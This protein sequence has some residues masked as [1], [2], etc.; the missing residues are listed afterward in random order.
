MSSATR[1][2]I[3]PDYGRRIKE[4]REI[5]GLTQTQLAKL[6]GV[7]YAS[8]NRWENSQSRP[9]NLAW[10]RI[11]DLELSLQESSIQE[12]N[13]IS[14]GSASHSLDFSAPPEV[15]STIAEAHRLAYGHLFNPT[16]ASETSLIDPLPHQR[17]AV[18][19][20]MLRQSPLRFLL[21]DDAGA[22]K[23]IMT[24]LY[25]REMLARRLI[26]RVLIV[27]PAGLV[28]N[29]ERE[30]RTLFRLRFR[31][32][33][34]LDA[35]AAN[36][37]AAPESDLVIVSVDTLAG[38]RMFAHLGDTATEPYDLVVFDEAHKLS[39][40]RQPDF[41]VRKTERYR[42]AEAIAGAG[43][44]GSR[45]AI[46]WSAQH[47]LLLTAT[48]HMGKDLPYYY[49]WRLLL[50][51]TLPT[52]EAFGH[53]QF[54]AKLR[55]RHFIRRTKEELVRFDG[56]PLF[57][58]RE[59]N[60]FS[61]ALTQGPGSEQE[62][63]DATTD[64]IRIYYNKARVLNRSAARL[65]MSVF[66]RRL[67]SS[68]YALMRS[69][70]RRVERLEDMIERIRDGRLTE[71]QLI[72]QQQRLHSPDDA[73]EITTADE[74]AEGE[75]EP[76]RLEEF[77]EQVLGGVIA[78][79]LAELEVERLK[80][81]DLLDRA[82]SL[83]DSGEESKFEK[84]REVLEDPKYAGEKFIIFTEH[85]DTADFLVRRLEGL[86]FTGQIATMH[87]GM[88]YQER[89]RQVEFF[90]RPGTN[91]GANFLVATDAAGEGIN[92]Q[93]CWLM[94]N[95]DIPWN[96]ARLE[97]RMG[98]I[99]RYGQGHDPVVVA[100][101]VA[102]ATREGRVL[103]TL[104]EK[105][106]AIRLQLQ[107]D[108]VFDVIGRLFEGVSI[109]DYIEQTLTEGESGEAISRLEGAL[110]E[111][112]VRAIQE[113]E[114]RLFGQVGDVARELD[115][116]NG[117]ADH[118]VYRRLLPG[119][120]HRFVERAMPLLDLRIDGDLDSTFRLIPTEP[121]ALDPLLPALESRQQEERGLLT[122]YRP[123]QAAGAVW[124]HPG[125]EVFDR[126]SAS[127]VERYGDDGLRGSV[128]IDPYATH[129][130]LFHI[131]LASVE[132]A[133]ERMDDSGVDPISQTLENPL[134]R[135]KLVDSRLV[136]LRQN[137]DGTVEEA[138]VEH[139]LLLKGAADFAPGSE[140]LAATARSL[141]QGAEGF[142]QENVINRIVQAH[143]QRLIDDLD[144][145]LRF[146]AR[147][148]DY[149]AAELTAARARLTERVQAGDHR[150][151]GELDRVRERQRSL[152]AARANRIDSIQAE[153]DSIR[154][155][156]LEFLVHAL[157]VPSQDPEEMEQYDA[158]VEAI[159][160]QVA[161]AYEESFNAEVTDVSHPELARRAGLN[162]WPGFD[163]LSKRPPAPDSA[164][165]KLAIEVKGRRG[166][167]GVQLQ[168]NEW[169]SACNNRDTYWLYVVFDCATPHPR[170]V[171]VRDPFG[172]LL[173]KTR[174]STAYTITES[175][176]LEAAE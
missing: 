143:R 56:T 89:E 15:V 134:P 70:E 121:R 51:E 11:I 137:G 176:I 61:Y 47:L 57:P 6:I 42:L 4:A 38:E 65:A 167:G 32:I 44:D 58:I 86:G 52:Y 30:M 127:V 160:I 147:G 120:V 54:P 145:R 122:V 130:Y 142:V 135:P 124:M 25:V 110:T 163:L 81:S 2:S 85:R 108:K 82:R 146:V 174:E 154:P 96:P 97:Q 158:D 92:L 175:E 75:D 68:T 140:P 14:N 71:E 166:R 78:H 119:Y 24:G 5:A 40:D 153:P 23:T 8:V 169:G 148:F 46:R 103:K 29:W 141:V 133:P 116:L 80:V 76:D 36:P 26:Q 101:L 59:C 83:F 49:L 170:L 12:L 118:E 53:E 157:I 94:V 63:Y 20:H 67:A 88:P 168:D 16:F 77:E 107:S 98:R 21:A 113:R 99:H 79:S 159:A 152:S 138:P 37:F 128:F 126:L 55:K 112:Q 1:T 106:E 114:H 125:E 72:H 66:Q 31:V 165:E 90:R 129:P 9:N 156:K 111:G 34:G 87:G 7:S 35:R 109:K 22:G 102:G 10:Q 84:L 171:R 18:Y 117:A 161:T 50:P 3:P 155:G 27:P 144:E 39:A 45:W 139:L 149:Q 64:Y 150:M 17:L 93:F 164:S 48:P 105:L 91:G 33:T 95:Y 132:Q 104:L 162:S 131:A 41:R 151:A 62:L 69:F 115:R 136:G 173:A 100:N 43:A 13:L 60:S 19:D 123:D 73:F 74:Q 172:K 28:G